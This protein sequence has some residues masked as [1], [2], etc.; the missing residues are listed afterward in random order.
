LK[1]FVFSAGEQTGP[2]SKEAIRKELLD[3]TLKPSDLAWHNRLRRWVPLSQIAILEPKSRMKYPMPPNPEDSPFY[4][5]ETAGEV[6]PRSRSGSALKGSWVSR[7]L[8]LFAN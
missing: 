8:K 1:I 2:Y 7:F 3:G 6:R 4:S 5:A